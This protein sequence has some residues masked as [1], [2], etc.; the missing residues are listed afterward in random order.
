MHSELFTTGF[1]IGD[2][3]VRRSPRRGTTTEA[4][5]NNMD[6][7]DIE[8]INQWRKKEEERGTE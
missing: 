5:D 1:F 6:T 3:S 4:E 7:A 8:L 2:F